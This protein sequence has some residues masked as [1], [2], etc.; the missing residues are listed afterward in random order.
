VTLTGSLGQRPYF[1]DRI[2]RQLDGRG[3][4]LTA[5][6]EDGPVGDVYLWLEPA[7]EP[8]IRLFLPDTPLLTHLEIRADRRARGMGTALIQAAERELAARGYRAVALAV[9]LHNLRAARLYRRL[10][11]ADWDHPPVRCYSLTDGNGQRA[12]EICRIL[13]KRLQGT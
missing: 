11:Y 13:V 12:V 1:T 7:E 3:V 6:H 4:L 9:E 2:E 8:E 5:W 10:G